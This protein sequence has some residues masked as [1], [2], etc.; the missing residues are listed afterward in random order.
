MSA[1]TILLRS[2]LTHVE[3]MEP[4]CED[5]PPSSPRSRPFATAIRD[6]VSAIHARLVDSLGDSDGDGG[7]HAEVDADAD[8]DYARDTT[9]PVARR[10]SVRRAKP[11][12]DAASTAAARTTRILDHLGGDVPSPADVVQGLLA[13]PDRAKAADQEDLAFARLLR[14][15]PYG[16]LNDWEEAL[17]AMGDRLTTTHTSTIAF[18]A[19][20][21]DIA[22]LTERLTERHKALT[23]T[24]LG[25]TANTIVSF[26]LY[27]VDNIKFAA[28]WQECRGMPG[29]KK[30]ASAFF[31]TAFIQDPN[32]APEFLG[33]TG[34]ATQRHF[35]ALAPRFKS[36]RTAT[37]HAI[38]A[39]GRLLRLYNMFGAAVLLDTTWAVD[40]LVNAHSRTFVPV[41]NNILATV[42]PAQL[43]P[44]ARARR[45][46]VRIIT[47]LGGDAVAAHIQHFLDD[48][49][50]A[51]VTAP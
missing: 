21:D 6:R 30:W 2:L 49:P 8:A 3:G 45:A 47:V 35:N 39:R 18:S 31:K 37:R 48:Y 13:Q 26:I 40:R 7:D 11:S 4:L 23:T 29:G 22:G 25:N 46:L 12:S 32:I 38:S 44:H 10:S 9:P 14:G 20:H 36:W 17:G 5:L 15:L 24:L 19:A 16:S 27:Q 50:A 41:L 51:T 43:P 34:P 42:V 1:N 33:L 28:D